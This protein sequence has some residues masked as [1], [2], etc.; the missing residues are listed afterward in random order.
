MEVRDQKLF[1]SAASGSTI[2]HGSGSH[3][4]GATNEQLMYWNGT[5]WEDLPAVLQGSSAA[6]RTA[7]HADGS[8][9]WVAAGTQLYS[10][11]IAGGKF[12]SVPLDGMTPDPKVPVRLISAIARQGTRT[13]I[14]RANKL[15][16]AD[17]QNQWATLSVDTCE[18]GMKGL[19]RVQN[20]VVAWGARNVAT[21]QGTSATNV[22]ALACD[23][24]A[25]IVGAAPMGQ[26]EV[27][28][29]VLQHEPEA[30]CGG[31]KVLQYK[32]GSVQPF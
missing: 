15:R 24:E 7:L 10:G 5:F 21:L 22:V 29:A 19:D 23:A 12:A 31:L 9:L 4:V 8:K 20:R 18:S 30:S 11:P 1:C 28:F 17:E 2:L 13:W 25:A 14:V 3:T 27:I 6:A 16:V 26:T 32:N